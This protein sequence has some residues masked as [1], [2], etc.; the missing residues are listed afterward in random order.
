MYTWFRFYIVSLLQPPLFPTVLDILVNTFKAM[1]CQGMGRLADRRG[2]REDTLWWLVSICDAR[3]LPPSGRKTDASDFCNCVGNGGRVKKLQER[4][5]RCLVSIYHRR[6]QRSKK[7]GSK[8]SC[9]RTHWATKWYAH[10][11]CPLNICLN[12]FIYYWSQCCLEVN[13]WE[14]WGTSVDFSM[15]TL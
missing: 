14:Q 13:M 15:Y 11:Q 5:W 4:G 8:H 9:V 3:S 2:R 6:S 10:E 7:G 12:G 1:H